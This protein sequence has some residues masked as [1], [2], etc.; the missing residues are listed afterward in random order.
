MKNQLT[1]LA[2]GSLLL[3]MTQV[4]AQQTLYR[5]V[6]DEGLVHYSDRVPPA[7]ANRE[8]EILNDHGVTVGHV[9]RA[10]SDEEVAERVRVA[11]LEEAEQDAAREQA[12]QDRVLLA[13]Y[14]SVEEIERLRDQRLDLLEAQS[15][16]TEQYLNNL[17]QR[18]SELQQDADRFKPYSED[19]DALAIPENL[20]LDITG[21]AGSIELYEETLRNSRIQQQSLAE[22]FASDIRRFQQLTGT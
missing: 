1:L 14:L 16:V 18:L 6:D 22:T 19:P 21:T 13:T 5:W 4:S 2:L 8:L 12:E 17:T 20:E 9:D 10:A 7:D 15:N 3:G 11:A